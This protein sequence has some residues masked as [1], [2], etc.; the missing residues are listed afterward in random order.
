MIQDLKEGALVFVGFAPWRRFLSHAIGKRRHFFASKNSRGLLL[1]LW[2]VRLMLMP[3]VSVVVWGLKYPRWLKRFCQAIHVPFIY[4][5]DGFIRSVGLGATGAQPASLIFDARAPYFD[6]HC[7][8]DL[9][10]L[11]S[12]YDFAGDAVLHE[13]AKRGIE[14]LLTGKISKYNLR[15]TRDASTLFGR[16]TGKKILVIGQVETD[17][18]ILLGCDKRWTNN[19]LV[20]LARK[21]NP[22]AQII[23]KPHPEVLHGVRKGITDPRDVS[24]I[25]EILVEDVSPSDALEAADHVYTMTSLMGFEALLRGKLVTCVGMPFYA[26]WGLTDDRQ[27]N[28]RRTRR[29]RVVDVFAAAYILYP[30]YFDPE[31]G[32][33]SSFERSVE[34]LGHMI[35]CSEQQI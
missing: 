26:G 29:L 20:R 32:D 21:E 34:R 4:C 9:E 35:A 23:Y 2:P 8:S 25:C 18:S 1:G 31:T 16:A 13:R 28:E 7:E 3:S 19:D 22:D 33:V 11:L 14:L 30:C 27:I 12:T 6:A 5:E 24:G 10:R 17:A 15:G